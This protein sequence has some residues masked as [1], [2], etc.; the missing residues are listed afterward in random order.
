LFGVSET[1]LV[2]KED[3]IFESIRFTRFD[4]NSVTPVRDSSIRLNRAIIA[5]V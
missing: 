4:K 2:K 3:A 1:E 5:F